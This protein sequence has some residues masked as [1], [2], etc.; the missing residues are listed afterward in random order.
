[1]NGTHIALVV[2][3]EAPFQ[4]GNWENRFKL[5]V[6]GVYRPWSDYAVIDL[7]MSEDWVIVQRGLMELELQLEKQR[8]G[9]ICSAFER[10]ARIWSICRY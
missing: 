6:N 2:D 8:I 5:Y 1:M 9:P 3:C 10:D 4:P 7:K